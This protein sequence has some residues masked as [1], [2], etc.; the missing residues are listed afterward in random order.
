MCFGQGRPGG[1][2]PQSEPLAQSAAARSHCRVVWW[3]PK[4]WRSIR[5]AWEISRSS[6][7]EGWGFTRWA[8]RA[9]S[10]VDRA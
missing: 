7:G 9:D 4:R 8:V 1:A 2:Y 3:M 10:V 6:S 5:L